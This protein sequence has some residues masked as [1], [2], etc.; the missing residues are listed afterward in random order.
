MKKPCRLSGGKRKFDS[1]ESA[2]QRA[3]EIMQRDPQAH[4]ATYRCHH[5]NH[6]HLTTINTPAPKAKSGTAKHQP[7]SV[8]N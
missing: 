2:L 3:G 6:W 8:T 1:H 7:C 4:F 5:C